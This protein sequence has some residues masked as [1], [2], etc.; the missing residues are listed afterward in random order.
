MSSSVPADEPT[1]PESPTARR[2][3]IYLRSLVEMVQ[4]VKK[5]IPHLMAH[6][7]PVPYVTVHF[8]TCSQTSLR[9]R[10]RISMTCNRACENMNAPRLVDF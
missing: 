3:A 1:L 4:P 10:R 2:Q 6:L 8:V 5:K 7:L 9:R